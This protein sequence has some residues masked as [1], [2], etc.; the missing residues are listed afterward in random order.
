LS[1]FWGPPRSL[2][3][4]RKRLTY[5]WGLTESAL[6]TSS[7]LSCGRSFGLG[8]V[9]GFGYWVVLG[10]TSSF[11]HSGV[12]PPWLAAWLPNLVFATLALSI[13]LFGEER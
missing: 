12:I 10:F 2:E 8:L 7:R 9:I 11:G 13:F 4:R 5:R 1:E 6:C 3:N